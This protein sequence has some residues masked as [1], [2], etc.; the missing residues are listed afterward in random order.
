MVVAVSRKKRRRFLLLFMF[1]LFL[2]P[3]PLR[4]CGWCISKG[5]QMDDRVGAFIVA[6]RCDALNETGGRDL[7]VYVQYTVV[8]VAAVTAS[9][10][11]VAALVAA[12]ISLNA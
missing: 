2:T 7:S 12:V 6:F 4:K 8:A 10:A 1:L 5:V 9:V 11:A 3:S